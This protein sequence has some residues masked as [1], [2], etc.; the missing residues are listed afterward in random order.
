MGKCFPNHDRVEYISGAVARRGSDF[1]LIANTRIHVDEAKDGGYLFRQFLVDEEPERDV[2]RIVDDYPGFVV[3]GRKVQLRPISRCV[4]YGIPPGCKF[5]EIGRYR[6]VPPWLQDG[7]PVA[8]TCRIKDRGA[9]CREPG[10]PAT[11]EAGGV[12]DTQMRPVAGGPLRGTSGFGAGHLL[13][14]HQQ[15]VSRARPGRP[16]R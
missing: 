4:P 6:R 15:T 9:Q 16:C 11:A 5:S 2:V 13:R 3:D 1:A 7:R 10:T 12:C 8:L 14:S